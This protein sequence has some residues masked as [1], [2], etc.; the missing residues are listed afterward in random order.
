LLARRHERFSPRK[1]KNVSKNRPEMTNLNHQYA[2]RRV[3]IRPA[4]AA[5]FAVDW[6]LTWL[7]PAHQ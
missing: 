5:D 1:L 2:I 7:L 3:F 4:L 6:P